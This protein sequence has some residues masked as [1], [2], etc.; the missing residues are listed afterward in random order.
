MA[1]F[2]ASFYNM[3]KYK[4]IISS[5]TLPVKVNFRRAG[6][7]LW[8]IP[9]IEPGSESGGLYSPAEQWY[10]ICVRRYYKLQV[11]LLAAYA[12]T[13]KHDKFYHARFAFMVKYFIFE[14]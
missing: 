4:T 5:H 13:A 14:R 8:K 10:N 12:A 7:N 1:H 3:T 11:V 9:Y 2:H 6:G